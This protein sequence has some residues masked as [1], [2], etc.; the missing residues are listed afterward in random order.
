[1]KVSPDLVEF[2]KRWEG[3][4]LQASPDPLVPGVW[5]VGYGHRLYGT[6]RPTWTREQADAALRSDLAA[7]AAGVDE[8]VMVPLAQNEFDA[9]VSLAYNVGNGAVSRSTLMRRLNDSDFYGAAEEFLRWDKAN[10]K[11]VPG[12]A[13]RRFAEQ[14]MFGEGDYSGGP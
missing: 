7:V 11:R 3:L 6:E 14:Q 12:L 1:M 2:V 5:D 13:K 10:G 9:V 8:A 4:K